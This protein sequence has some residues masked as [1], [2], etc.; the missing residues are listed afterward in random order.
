MSAHV[1]AARG[2]DVTICAKLAAD[3]LSCVGLYG[4]AAFPCPWVPQQNSPILRANN[5]RISGLRHVM[6][7]P[8][9]EIDPIWQVAM[10]RQS[11]FRGAAVS[12]ALAHGGGLGGTKW[13]QLE[14]FRPLLKNSR[15]TQKG[16]VCGEFHVGT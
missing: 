14:Q 6:T 10:Y 11:R 9:K 1:G 13:A 3:H 16:K 2:Q 15:E 5:K 12:R 8:H 7:A 4:T